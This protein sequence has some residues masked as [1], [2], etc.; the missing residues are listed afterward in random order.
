[1]AMTVPLITAAEVKSVQNAVCGVAKEAGSVK[2]AVPLP[3]LVDVFSGS[4]FYG[5]VRG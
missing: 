3:S 4:K 2:N 1:M 5:R